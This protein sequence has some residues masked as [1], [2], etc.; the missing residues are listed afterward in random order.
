MKFLDGDH[1][2]K[3]DNEL[4]NY[5]ISKR[6]SF[7]DCFKAYSHLRVKNWIVRSGCRNGESVIGSS[8]CL[9]GFSVDERTIRRWTPERC[10][11]DQTVVNQ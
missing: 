2:L 11:E 8:P 10:R 1:N 7:A 6:A 5:I 3:T 4:C 9:D